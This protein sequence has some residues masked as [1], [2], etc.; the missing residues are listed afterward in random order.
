MAFIRYG[1]DENMFEI[2]DDEGLGVCLLVKM[3]Y[4]IQ[5]IDLLS[6]EGFVFRFVFVSDC[7]CV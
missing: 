1:S 2:K 4:M 6:D 7:D 5:N 3:N